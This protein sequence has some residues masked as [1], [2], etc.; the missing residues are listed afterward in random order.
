MRILRVLLAFA[1]VIAGV[2]S[3]VGSGG[4][5]SSD[6]GKVHIPPGCCGFSGPTA[7]LDIT[8]AN[9]QEVTATVVQAISQ[10]FDFADKVGGQIFPSPPSAPDLLPGKSKFELIATVAET[11]EDVADTCT[12]SGT[13]TIS[14]LAWNDPEPMLLSGGDTF[15]LTFD[16]CDDGEGY[17]IDGTFRLSVAGLVGDPGTE[18]FRLR[19]KLH[20]NMTL[21]ITSGMN[22]LVASV[23]I[24]D[25]QLDWNSLS[26]PVVVLTT[27]PQSLELASQADIYYWLYG[28]EYSQTV[29]ADISM[30]MTLGEASGPLMESGVLGSYVSY[31]IVIPLQAPDG[32]DPEAG[33]IQISGGDGNGTIRIVIESSN[34][35]RLEIDADGDGIVEDY[36]YTTWAALQGYADVSR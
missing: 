24:T 6:L 29:N 2:V 33:G 32:Q 26:F 35:V 8:V 20:E 11:G 3:S 14:G 31:S 18:V 4:G 9:A 22:T 12:V 30:P 36:Q 13:V 27:L 25:I 17:T 23:K 15:Y 7:D 16:N 19:Y 21:T 5:G 1:L 34:S 28:G 10:L